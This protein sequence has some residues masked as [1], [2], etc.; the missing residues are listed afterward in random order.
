[1]SFR[2]PPAA[3]AAYFSLFIFYRLEPP[4]RRDNNL[5][6]LRNTN[7]NNNNNTSNNN[8]V[9]LTVCEIYCCFQNAADDNGLGV[10][11]NIKVIKCNGLKTK[12]FGRNGE[13]EYVSQV[14][15][16]G[17]CALITV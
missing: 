11:K 9:F 5:R 15:V 10:S 7:N 13:A 17:T 8:N 6:S 12:P 3:A 2:P 4:H 1:M 14:V 16:M